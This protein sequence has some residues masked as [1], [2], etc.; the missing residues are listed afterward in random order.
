M[1]NQPSLLAGPSNTSQRGG[2]EEGN[3]LRIGIDVGGTAIKAGLVDTGLGVII[4]SV[5][6]VPTP[7]PAAPDAV[8]KAI[9]RLVDELSGGANAAPL[10]APVGVALPAIIRS[11]TAWSAAN[12]HD[13]W[14]GLNVDE[15]LSACLQRNVWA[16]N[17]ADAAGI[18]EILHGAGRD[19]GGTVLVITLGTGIG[20][21]LAVKGTLVPN[22]EFGHLE[23]D[24]HDAESRASAVARERDGIGWDEYSQRLQRYFSHLEFLLSPD[25]IIVGGG[26]SA[27]SEKFL[28]QLDLKSPII[29]AQLRNSAGVVGAAIQATRPRSSEGKT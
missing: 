19:T 5:L 8:A 2:R 26:V 23:I 27:S 12:I 21:A 9:G 16:L 25:L 28:P 24:G 15:F 17:D 11:G 4:G 18:A 10:T 13:D 20:S 22:T 14:V 3:S 1:N 7:Q 6:Q 29:P